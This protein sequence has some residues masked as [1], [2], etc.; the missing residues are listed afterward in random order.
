MKA[1]NKFIISTALG[2]ACFGLG[3][4]QDYVKAKN[5]LKQLGAQ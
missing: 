4:A 1:M 3:T 5:A 2:A